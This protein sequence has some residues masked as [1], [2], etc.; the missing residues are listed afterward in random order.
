MESI[1]TIDENRLEKGAS[2]FNMLIGLPDGGELPKDRL[3]QGTAPHIR[4]RLNGVGGDFTEL[5]K[6]P[7]LAMPEVSPEGS[8]EVARVGN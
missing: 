8:S 7:T 1:H 6:L 4:E 3:L 5:L 2:L